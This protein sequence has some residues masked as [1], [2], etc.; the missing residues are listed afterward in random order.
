M[1]EH[2]LRLA[3]P[4]EAAPLAAP[5]ASAFPKLPSS[6]YFVGRAADLRGEP[7]GAE[8]AG[9]RLVLFRSRGRLVALDGDCGHLGADLSRGR[10][11]DGCIECPF[12]GWMYDDRGRCVRIP[13]QDVIPERARQRPVPVAERHGLVF[14]HLAKP[15]SDPQFPLP[16]FFTAARGPLVAGRPVRYVMDCPW[17]LLAANAFDLQHFRLVHGRELVGGPEIDCPS[18]FARRIRFRSRVVGNSL[19]DR[20]IRNLLS[21]TVDVCITVWAG[22]LIGVQAELGRATS[23]LL[24][25]AT[26]RE[27]DQT[28]VSLIVFLE[29]GPLW[30]RWLDPLSLSVRRLLTRAFV[31]EDPRRVRRVR[32]H[33]AAFVEADRPMVEYF[34]WLAALSTT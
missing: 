11:V 18:G 4:G 2:G 31:D 16:E 26:P 21:S 7:V 6:W 24:F 10:V 22:N 9:R 34:H 33:P 30:R 20:L 28:D 5:P 8:V 29:Q 13:A 3:V 19:A 27:D 12:H 15:T 23:R 14:V 1:S 32:Y 17:Y 25:S